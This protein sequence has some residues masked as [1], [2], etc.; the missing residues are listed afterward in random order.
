MRSDALP[1]LCYFTITALLC[2]RVAGS[3]PQAAQE[4]CSESVC[5]CGAGCYPARGLVT[6]AGQ[7]MGMGLRC[8]ELLLFMAEGNH[9]I[10]TRRT[11]RRNKTR[12][13][14]H[15]RKNGRYGGKHRPIAR[16]E[17]IK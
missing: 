11:A 3:Q 7:G 17:T 9:R 5:K 8:R 14:G 16:L 6:C 10:D 13:R 12:Y 1:A 4:Q 15:N 2:A